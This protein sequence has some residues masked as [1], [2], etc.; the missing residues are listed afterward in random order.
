MSKF[1]KGVA[2]AQKEGYQVDA[3]TS[4]ADSGMASDSPMRVNLLVAMSK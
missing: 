1:W 2:R 3:I 4:Y